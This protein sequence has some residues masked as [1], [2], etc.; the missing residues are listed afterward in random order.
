MSRLSIATEFDAPAPDS[1]HDAV[2]VRGLRAWLARLSSGET[3]T[4][5]GT[6]VDRFGLGYE[7]RGEAP[8]ERLPRLATSF[9]NRVRSL[10]ANAHAAFRTVEGARDVEATDAAALDAALRVVEEE[11]RAAIAARDTYAETLKAI[12]LY[13]P[14][15][16]SRRMAEQGLTNQPC[17]GELRAAPGGFARTFTEALNG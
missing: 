3:L 11:W 7:V 9:E 4:V 15:A 17:T 14:D 2:S 16:R 10:R 1:R 12:R 6:A 5:P 8:Q 13:A